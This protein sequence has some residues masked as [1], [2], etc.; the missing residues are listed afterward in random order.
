MR[1]V[2]STAGCGNGNRGAC[3]SKDSDQRIKTSWFADPWFRMA[4]IDGVF[5]PFGY[6]PIV[7]GS[8]L[9]IERPFVI[10]HELAHA[11]GYPAED[12]ANLIAFFATALSKDPKLQYSGWLSLWLYL[13]TRQLD[14][15][16]NAGPRSD[17]A[18]IVERIR[19]GEIRWISNF[20][21]AVL[22]WYLKTNN[23]PE[24]IRSYSRVVLLAAGT[25][26]YWNRFQ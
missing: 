8:L 12:D 4:G 20:Q 6:E 24:G 13:R 21:T 2:L 3:V 18:R 9:D 25:E 5:N 15:L 23:V 22:D 17:I 1:G 16:L 19:S 26:P 7:S 10:A 14:Q 11:R